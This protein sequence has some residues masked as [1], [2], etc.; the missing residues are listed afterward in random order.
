MSENHRAPSRPFALLAI[1]GLVV[2]TLLAGSLYAG[3]Q[4]GHWKCEAKT[5]D[6]LDKM[7]AKLKEKGWLGID[8]E[9]IDGGWYRISAV[10]AG[11][12]AA[13]AGLEVG[14][15]LLTLDGVKVNAANKEELKKVKKGLGVGSTVSYVVKRDGTKQQ[16]AA[17]LGP[18]PEAQ[19]AEQ[20]GHH[21]LEQHTSKQIATIY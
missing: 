6:C 7:A 14:D 19:I 15:V 12:P 11:S 1:V 13:Q 16:V 17:T 21:M 4:N 3:G 5:Q 20:V 2:V 8:T 18:M 9:K 10:H